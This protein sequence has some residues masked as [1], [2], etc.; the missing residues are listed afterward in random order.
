MALF[1][2]ILLYV[3]I[4]LLIA[5]FILTAIVKIIDSRYEIKKFIE[6]IILKIKKGYEH[7]RQYFCKKSNEINDDTGAV[8]N[9]A[10]FYDSSSVWED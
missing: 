6:K 4:I 2:E 10:E 7:F 9:G 5:D 1:I 3:V 8:C